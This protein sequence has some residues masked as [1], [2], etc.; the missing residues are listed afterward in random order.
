MEDRRRSNKKVT[1]AVGTGRNQT[2]T[3]SGTAGSSAKG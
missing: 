1:T 3:K 2:P